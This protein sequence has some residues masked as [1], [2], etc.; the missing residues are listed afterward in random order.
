M[1]LRD[2]YLFTEDPLVILKDV[3]I[4][5]TFGML[6][7][8]AVTAFVES[9]MIRTGTALHMTQLPFT[10]VANQLVHSGLAFYP[11]ETRE[12]LSRTVALLRKL[13]R[14]GKL[15]GIAPARGEA[16]TCD[17][18]EARV[19]AARLR[20]ARQPVEGLGILVLEAETKYGFSRSSIYRWHNA[21]WVR[22]AFVEAGNRF[23]NEGDMAFAHALSSILTDYK[24]GKPLFPTSAPSGRPPKN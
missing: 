1:N 11:D 9:E 23:F 13:V 24:Q 10:L 15:A 18:D 12:D 8:A 3:L 4:F 7:W 20:Q 5:L 16:G 6:I 2:S 14:D 17:I 21:G 22:L 19:I